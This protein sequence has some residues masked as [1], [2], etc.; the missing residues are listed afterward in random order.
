MSDGVNIIHIVGRLG[1]DPEVRFTAAGKPVCTISVATKYQQETTWHRA[2]L[3]G[4]TAKFAGEYLKKGDLVYLSGRMDYRKY[5]KDGSERTSAEISV[6]TLQALGGKDR[7]STERTEAPS[8]YAD[9][10]GNQA[11][12]DIPF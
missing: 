4:P 9:P 3:W 2:T 6:S 7:G 1:Q 8:D 10:N 5:V 12:D 11:D